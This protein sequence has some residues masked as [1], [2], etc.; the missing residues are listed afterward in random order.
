MRDGQRYW[1]GGVAG[2]ARPS[3]VVE[4]CVA[5]NSG[6][7]SVTYGWASRCS[8][9]GVSAGAVAERS[10]ALGTQCEQQS[11]AERTRAV[12]EGKAGLPQWCF[13]RMQQACWFTLTFA[14]AGPVKA[15]STNKSARLAA[16]RRMRGGNQAQR[17]IRG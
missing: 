13:A 15:P 12:L 11:F 17:T 1:P 6:R 7:N 5:S 3:G 10:T 2:G 4:G 8:A 14:H 9:T 16:K